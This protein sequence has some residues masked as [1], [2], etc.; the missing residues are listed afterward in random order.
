M[1]VKA[2]LNKEELFRMAEEYQKESILNP[3]F[4]QSLYAVLDEIVYYGGADIEYN[5]SVYR[6]KTDFDAIKL[7]LDIYRDEICK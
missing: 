1:E 7:L 2:M 3:D 4:W 5:G 6:V